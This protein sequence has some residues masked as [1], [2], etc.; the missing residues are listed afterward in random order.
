MDLKNRI[1]KDIRAA[2]DECGYPWEAKL[3]GSHI[4]LIL[5]GQ[6][7][8]IYPL[9]GGTKLS[10]MGAQRAVMNTISQ[11]KRAVEGLKTNNVRND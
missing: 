6:M 1:H 10:A 9:N 8:G 11:I 4:K 2:L 7:V 5:A 3:G